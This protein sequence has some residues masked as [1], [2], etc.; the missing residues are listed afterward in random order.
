MESGRGPC[1]LVQRRPLG[2]GVYTPRLW[3]KAIHYTAPHILPG[4]FSVNAVVLLVLTPGDAGS[5]GTAVMVNA[6]RKD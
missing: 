2:R 4:S 1:P 3:F 6:H 5:G